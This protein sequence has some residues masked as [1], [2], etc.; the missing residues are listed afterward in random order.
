MSQEEGFKFCLDTQ[1]QQSPPFG[2]GLPWARKCL[3]TSQFT[4]KENSIYKNSREGKL[5]PI[6]KKYKVQKKKE[7]K[8]DK[9]TCHE[10]T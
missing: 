1:K 5:E 3:V 8:K 6:Q 7:K 4:L 9:N 10:R 2:S